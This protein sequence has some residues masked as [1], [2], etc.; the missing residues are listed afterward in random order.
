MDAI[1]LLPDATRSLTRSVD[2]LPD[3]AYAEPS[4]LPGWTRGHVIAHLALNAEGLAGVLNGLAAGEDVP[5][6]ASNEARDNDVEELATAE[7]AELRDRLLTATTQFADACDRMPEE[8]WTGTVHRTPGGD[9]SFPASQVPTKRLGE[10]EIHHADLG[11]GYDRTMWSEEFATDIVSN[12][13]RRLDAHGPLTLRASDL[14]R[15]WQV[16]G[17]GGPWIA[18]TVADL[19]WWL[20]GRGDGDGLTSETGTLPA[21]GSW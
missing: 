10:V 19:G 1:E 14:G 15:S 18:G 4:L 12:M 3:E 6:Y 20:T 7:P 11:S 21:A 13:S 2:G 16:G 5:M 17:E 9:V 8:A